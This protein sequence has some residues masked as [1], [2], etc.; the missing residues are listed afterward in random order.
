MGTYQVGRRLV[1]ASGV[2]EAHLGAHDGRPLVISRLSAPWS[3]DGSFLGR[4]GATAGALAEVRVAEVA[5]LE[6][7]GPGGDGFWF[8]ET[9]GDGEPLRA[10]MTSRLGAL[11]PDECV[12]IAERVAQG[13]AALHAIELVHG[14]V[15]ASSVFVGTTG[16]VQLLHTG[17]AVVAGTHPSRGPARSEPH[18]IAPEQL[19]SPP[20]PATD[21]FRLGLLLLEMLTARS[22]FVAADPL[23]V[24][25]LAERFQGVAASQLL[26]VPEPLKPLLTS[27]LHRD[28]LARPPADEVPNALQLVA[29]TLNLSTGDPEL[30]RGFR[31][32]LPERP[33][34]TQVTELRL[35]APRPS[36]PPPPPASRARA[37]PPPPTSPGVVVGRVETRRMTWDELEVVQEVR[38]SPPLRPAMREA[39]IG[40]QLLRTGLLSA[41][42]LSAAQ[43][44]STLLNVPLS[45]ALELD[46]VVSEDALVEALG[47]ITHTSVVS[48]AELAGLDGGRAPLHLIPQA[49]AER[50]MAV[51]L[52]EKGRVLVVAVR[53]PL[54]APLLDE[55][56]RVSGRTVKAVRA[57][58]R[59]LRKA[60]A[61]L[62]GASPEPLA[63][64]ADA[65]PT[66]DEV[67]AE[68]ARLISVSGLDE[69]QTTLVE[70][71][72]AGFGDAGADGVALLQLS[73]ELARRLKGTDAEVDRARFVTAC[74]AA[75]NLRA[76]RPVWESPA[77]PGFDTT[78]GALAPAVRALV[79]G[80]F[81]PSRR[82]PSDVIGLAV[83]C[84]FAFAQAGQSAC[85]TPWQPV[86]AQL[87]SRHFPSSVL[88]ALARTLSS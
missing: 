18:A 4:F 81:E 88:D 52:S 17:L 46:G 14:D 26:G 49:D 9:T 41:A 39:L 87:K 56:K 43:A 36:S 62:Y 8:A 7:Y 10:L 47:A 44:R 65:L 20:T 2:V 3:Q 68:H 38:S 34:S 21:V 60:V 63:P 27:L 85:P 72:L 48:G 66:L 33:P 28:P 5:G 74:V 76:R 31:R 84:T 40:E 61:R 16:T 86:L 45:E 13:L 69:G 82:L 75:F 22:L 35:T 19:T 50:L 54:E 73:G 77:G 70:V 59:A 67:R 83:L 29:A 51:P 24:L 58:E 53:D 80:L 12:A 79:P 1:A 30:A 78:L 71:L 25:S 55:L 37:S 32:L 6:D 23:H 42:Q 57:G 64:G 15:S 11:T